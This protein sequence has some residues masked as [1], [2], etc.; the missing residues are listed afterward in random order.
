MLMKNANHSDAAAAK[1]AWRGHISRQADKLDVHQ[2]PAKYRA[3]RQPRK[4]A[5]AAM[6]PA[7]RP[8]LLAP[9]RARYEMSRTPRWRVII[10]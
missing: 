5:G 2:Q 8:A 4:A 6:L 3:R 10:S 1:I 9:P 7:L